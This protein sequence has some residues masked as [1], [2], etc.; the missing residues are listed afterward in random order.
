MLVADGV[1]AAR[2][3]VVPIFVARTSTVGPAVTD[4][5]PIDGSSIVHV[6][7]TSAR[8]PPSPSRTTT[9]YREVPSTDAVALVGE[10]S[11]LPAFTVTGVVSVIVPLAATTVVVIVVWPTVM[12]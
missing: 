1:P 7:A 12:A 3:V 5:V 11:T 9:P 4:S 6:A 2:T 10:M 8:S